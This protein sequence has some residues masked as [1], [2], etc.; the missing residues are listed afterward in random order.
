[1]IQERGTHR[2]GHVGSKLRLFLLLLLHFRHWL[3]DGE[4]V[5]R[6]RGLFC[7]AKII[8]CFDFD[9]F[10]PAHSARQTVENEISVG[11]TIKS[12]WELLCLLSSVRFLL[13]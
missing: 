8:K 3:S 5:C 1:M 6:G 12:D 13:R 11:L 9:F 7:V 4:A 10:S 2:G